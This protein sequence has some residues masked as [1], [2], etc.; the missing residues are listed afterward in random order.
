M[1]IPYRKKLTNNL[2]NYE[3]ITLEIG[4]EDEVNYGIETWEDA[5]KRLREMVNSNLKNEFIRLEGKK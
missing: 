5:F 3:S 2:G 1:Q 4:A